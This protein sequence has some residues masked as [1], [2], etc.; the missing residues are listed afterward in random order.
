MRVGNAPPCQRAYG[1]EG[2][3]VVFKLGGILYA[4]RV[5]R[6]V[7][8]AQC[9]NVLDTLCEIVKR[10]LGQSGNEV[11]IDGTEALLHRKLSRGIKLLRRV[12]SANRS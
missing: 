12:L 7:V 3:T 5:N 10:V 6:H 1:V 8:E 4:E 11:G 9:R 2:I